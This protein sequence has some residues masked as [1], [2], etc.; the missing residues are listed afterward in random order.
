MT[1]LRLRLSVS[2]ICEEVESGKWK[3]WTLCCSLWVVGLWMEDWDEAL[4]ALTDVSEA[5]AT[6]SVQLL[7]LQERYYALQAASQVCMMG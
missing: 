6:P 3:V 1:F 4:L 5:H 7:F 2:V